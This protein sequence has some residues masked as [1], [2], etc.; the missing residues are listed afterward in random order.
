MIVKYSDYL[1]SQIAKD[2]EAQESTIQILVKPVEDS[3][4]AAVQAFC[5]P[6]DAETDEGI[7]VYT[8]LKNM[9][10]VTLPLRESPIR[11]GVLRRN[12][13]S[14]NAWGVWSENSGDI[15]VACRD[16]MKELKISLHQSGKQHIAFTSES[17]LEMTEPGFPI[18][19]VFRLNGQPKRDDGV[20]SG[21]ARP[22]NLR[23]I[24]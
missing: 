8:N 21:P 9:R 6:E 4:L 14:S 2:I 3:S 12:G 11:F 10:D 19:G 16:N 13:L 5:E 23:C 18:L 22:V 20:I 15:Y 17:G 7:P 24:R 1:E